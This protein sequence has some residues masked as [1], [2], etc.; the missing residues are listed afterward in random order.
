MNCNGEIA[1]G[2]N[3]RDDACLVTTA[4]GNTRE[5]QATPSCGSRWHGH[6]VVVIFDNRTSGET[7]GNP[8]VSNL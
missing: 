6:T 1:T 3:G 8:D 5:P 4:Y 7:V 2:C